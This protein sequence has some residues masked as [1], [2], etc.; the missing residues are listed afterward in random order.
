MKRKFTLLIAALALLTMIVQPGRAWG[1]ESTTVASFSRSGTTNTTTGGE[2]TATFSAKTGYYQ[3]GNG[4]CYMQI[5]N[6]SAYWTT[7]P[8]SISFAALIGGGSGNTDLTDPVYVALLDANGAVISGTQT[9]VT[10][11]I[12][13]NTGDSYNISIPVTN[14]VYGVRLSHNKQSGFNVRY[15]SFSLSYV[16][17]GGSTT[18]PTTVTIDA[19]GITNNDVYVGT[20]AGSLTATVTENTNNTPISGATVTWT[21]SNTNAATIDDDGAVTLVAA[22]TT[23]I[24]ASYAG[25]ATYSSSSAT[26]NLEVV[27]NTPSSDQWVL[28]NLADLTADDVF[29]IVGNNGSNYAMANDN[30]TGSAPAA[31]SVTVANNEITST[32]AANIQWNISG[33]GADGYT[34]YP[35][36]STTTWLY[37]T[38]A[39]NGIRVGTN[40]DKAFTLHS[41][42]YLQHTTTSRFLGI[43]S[44]QDWRCYTDYNTNNIKNQTFAFYKKVTGGVVPPSI[45]A[46]NVNIAYNATNGSIAYTINNEPDPAGT[47]TAAVTDGDWLTLGTVGATVPFT[48]GVNPAATER[49]ATVTLTY[50]YDAK[51]SVTKD[52][53]VTQAGNPDVYMTISEVRAQGTGSVT[54]KG[55]VTSCVGTT[56][57]IQDNDAAICVYGSSLTVGDEIRVSGS[58]TTYN[59]LLE[60]TSPQV[61]VVSSGNVVDPEVMTVTEAVASTNQGWYIRIENATVSA[62]SGSNTTIAQGESTIV[63]RGISGVT[64]AVNDIISLNGNIGCYNGNQIANPQDVTV[65][66]PTEPTITLSSY[67]INAPVEGA[68]GVLT[69]THE[70]ITT[71]VP[72]VWFCNSEGTASAT[73]DWVTADINTDGNVEYI[74]EAND[75]AERTAYL[76]VKSGDVYSNLVTISQDE[77]VAPTYAELPF[78]FNGGKADI[79][80]TDGL[81]QE[82]LG[83]DYS[84][85]N[86]KLKFDGTGDWLLLQFN[87]RPGT[88]TFNIKGNGFSSGSTSTFKVQTSANGIT[89][90][91][92]AIYTELGDVETKSFDALDENVRYIKWIYTEKGA[93]SGGNVGLG[94]INLAAY[95][96]P[97]AS[98]AVDPASV[99][100]PAT[101][102][103][104]GGVTEGSLTLT[105]TNIT[106]TELDQLG[107]DYCDENG[108]LLTG[109]NTKPE[110]INTS[111]AYENE[112]YTLN[113]T[114]A[115]NTETTARVAYFKVYEVNSE[116][117]SNKVTVTQAAH[118]APAAS[119]TVTPNLVEAPA[120]GTGEGGVTEGSLTLT[121]ENITITELDQL[122]VDYCDENGTPLTGTNTKP[123]WIDTEFAFENE[124]YSLNYTIAENTETTERVAYF[125]VYEVNSEAYSNKVT[126]TQAGFVV[127]YAILP[128]EWE[129]GPRSEFEALNGTST[130]SVGDYGDNQGVYRM[131]LDND[132]DYIQV[133][134]NEQPG[135][136][137]VG[138]KMIGGASTSTITVQGSADGTTFTNVEALTISGSQNDELTLTTTNDFAATD[139]YV[140]LLFTKGSNVGVGPITIAQVDLTPSITVAPASLNLNC[141]GGDGELTV[142]HK[143]LADDP[144]LNVI[145]VESDGETI[146]TCDWIQASINTAG[147][148]AGHINA[149]TGEA[150]TAYLKV[151]G[152]DADN[153]LIKSNLVTFNQSA[154]TE[155]SIVFKNTTLDIVAGGEN[156]TMSFDYEGLGQNPT[157]SINFYESD[158]TTTATYPWITA[159]ITP[160]EKVDITVSANEGAARS[161]YFKVQ[162]VNGTV[163][164]ESNLVTINQAA[165]GQ[166]VQYTL[167]TS[168]NDLTPGYHYIIASEATE[169][170]LSIMDV[171]NGNNRGV[172]DATVDGNNTITFTSSDTYYD[173]VIS[174][175]ENN[176]WTI[177]DESTISTG[178]LYAASSSKNYLRTQ[179]SNDDN[180]IWSITIADDGAATIIAQGSNSNKYMR[181]NATLFSCYSATSSITDL[182]YIYKKNN[183]TDIH[184]YSP[185]VVEVE[186]LNTGTT[187]T[188]V[189]PNEILTVTNLTSNN[190][191]NLIVEDGGQLVFSGTGVQATMK[192]S[193]AH[194]GAKDVATDWY[195][196]AS[197]LAAN[198]ATN[199]VGNLTN[200][201]YDLYR[202]NEAAV[203]WEN[204]KDTEHSGGFN[205]L[206]VGRGYLYWNGSGSDITF[207]GELRN[208]DVA[209][210][211]KADGAGNYKGFNLIGNPFSQN[212][213]MSNITGVILSG[214][215]V[216][217][218]AGGWGASIDEIAPCQGFLVQVEAE[219]DITIT[220]PTSSGKSRANRDYLAF[221][222]A[223]SEYEDVAYA[224]FE[225]A[226]GLSKINHRNADIPMVY[227]PQD[228]QNYA[229][230]T[231]D[232]NTQAF[233][234]NFKAMTTGQYTLS[235]KAEGKYSYLHVIDRLTGE[236]IDML[237]D[238]E[239]SFIGSPRDNE[240]RFIVKL[241]YNANIDEI[242]V[243]DIFAY[244]NG[245]DII[246]NGN[247]ELQVFDVTGRMVMNTKINGIQTVNVPTTGIY[248]FRMVGE[249]VQTQKI[250]VR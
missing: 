144:Q 57:Y 46:S 153:N 207:A 3:D 67:A 200:G 29:V 98:I 249:S 224:M 92:L 213:T 242:E 211:L 159:E 240:A 44:S 116:T 230:A 38:N 68:D 187:P 14:N 126:V 22:G 184:Y 60:I 105:L 180:G 85:N 124:V 21:S 30:G 160:E 25:D 83:S 11:H 192:K 131:K 62:I 164:T 238:G 61:T 13:T 130:Y 161:A 231:M 72:N 54:T 119:I 150:R 77:Y 246:V 129:G 118:V 215:Y 2:F 81:Y 16:A 199:A 206:T 75:G 37:C 210:T 226:T 121:L 45:S 204:A 49:A 155:P 137:T 1:Q 171:Q 189:L 100:A 114:I 190:P 181:F 202:Y 86:P 222:V 134:T 112:V 47:L 115:P 59:G 120:T 208:A 175:D 154:Y 27:D 233:E 177:Y 241:S 186:T 128:F 193:T 162:G 139:R 66:Q 148:V 178:Y 108:T 234:L 34:F 167:I 145:F 218:Q 71:F 5:L 96:A 6:T 156:R 169:G 132:D 214:G 227:I 17:G 8:T 89:Y 9:A 12:T 247:G 217:T 76:K 80:G 133:K 41:S 55:I 228:G 4:D 31:V 235:Y 117:Y 99:E 58:L 79:E 101:G 146:T 70:N 74:V 103:G 48:C 42:G 56:G 198:V 223:N 243:N 229:I 165:A 84:G 194:A 191:D 248:I 135:I 35:N 136:V 149:N 32:V 225:E 151:T 91:D 197:P 216:L 43:Y 36:G 127:D 212:I 87:E 39:N 106:I 28:T 170:E 237:L 7:T 188:T 182:P 147:N 250:V 51:A 94:D 97:V 26:Y 93:T 73:Y 50:T 122:G 10:S 107:V 158:G 78:S 110:W 232:D 195:T 152:R 183:D 123:E 236:D 102:T 140:R 239:Y 172:K 196:I 104:E 82:G 163:N 53:T 19:S 157:F 203:M 209:Y 176:G 111:F 219:T 88:L 113:Y 205:E 173:F 168:V 69:V 141:D 24:T 95:E 143:N 185:S 166:T 244:Q 125:K 90:T 179:S 201:T 15:Y 63:V 20:A 220:K 142:T 40:D 221:T 64:L 65:Q 33:N 52:V 23:T 18:T 174:G 109:T 245:S 138:V